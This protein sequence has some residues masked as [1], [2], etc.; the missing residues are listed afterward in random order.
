MSN[1]KIEKI[2]REKRPDW[3]KI[4][5]PS[6]EN[7]AKVKS[8]LKNNCLNTVCKEAHCPNMAECWSCG[9]AAF[10]IL[11]DTCTRNCKYCNVRNGKPLPPDPNEPLNLAESIKSMH[12]R[13]AVITSVT[14]DDLADNGAGFWAEVIRK[15]KELNPNTTIE[16]LIPDFKGDLDLLN[17][18]LDAK[19][20][21][22]NHN[23]EA[24]PSVF[25]I[26]RPQADY[27]RSLEVLRHSKEMGF[28]TKSGIMMGLGETVEEV[29]DLMKDLRGVGVDIFTAG[30]YLQP[31]KEHYPV[32]RYVRPDEFKEVKARG[33]ELGF[34]H[35]D[36]GPLVRS[37]YHAEMH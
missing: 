23:V 29:V 27:K 3:L 14:R 2:N 10:M 25:P 33:L 13:H 12:L 36:A 30:Q 34:I 7:F 5:A 8:M 19:P 24:V 18:V 32:Q 31:T 22:L 21:I 16:V 35:I 15:A 28:I 11:G 17:I 26:V 9:T 6:G 20:D 1:C 37:S 4:K